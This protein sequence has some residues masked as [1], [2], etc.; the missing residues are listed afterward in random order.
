[1]AIC[2]SCKAEAPA[3]HRWC[4]ICHANLIN[5]TVGQLASPASRLAALF[6]DILIPVMAFITF[7]GIAASG[8]Q[9]A[10]GGGAGPVIGA[11]LLL[12]Y[13]GWALVLF[14]RG[15]TPGKSL[16]GLRVVKE[17]GQ[18]AGFGTML[19]REWIGKWISGLIFGL[20]YIW[21]LIDKDRQGWH[22]KLMS[23]Y[24]VK[25]AAANSPATTR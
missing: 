15:T 5:G 16:L 14:S 10:D 24:V 21:I 12:G 17:A 7:G 20:G 8:S 13:V 25:R 6:L 3:G 1:M 23:T 11:L 9:E 22:D 19:I 2:P 18:A 4:P